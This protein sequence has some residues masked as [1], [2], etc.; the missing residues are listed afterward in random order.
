M[1]ADMLKPSHCLRRERRNLPFVSLVIGLPSLSI[2][3]PRMLQLEQIFPGLVL[4]NRGRMG[5]V[6]LRGQLSGIVA[7]RG[8]TLDHG[9][10]FHG[11]H[12]S[13]GNNLRA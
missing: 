3:C 6:H 11:S 4:L 1:I 13:G 8:D 7:I 9:R 5:D 12:D 10:H 2:R